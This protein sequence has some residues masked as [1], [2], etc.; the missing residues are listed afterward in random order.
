MASLQVN[1]AL[2]DNAGH[3][4]CG[5][6]SGLDVAD[7]FEGNDSGYGATLKLLRGS[8]HKWVILVKLL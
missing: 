2:N 7:V 5:G 3:L 4:F 6:A 8:H 1:K